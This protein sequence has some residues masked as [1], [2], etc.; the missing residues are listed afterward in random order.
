MATSAE[1]ARR[2]Y[3]KNWRAKNRDRVRQYNKNFWQ[4]CAEKQ[5]AEENSERKGGQDANP[6][7]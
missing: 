2:E 6:N 1:E 7:H 3:Y 5:Q 4:R